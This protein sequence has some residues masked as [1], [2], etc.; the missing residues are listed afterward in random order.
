V[1]GLGQRVGVVG[2]VVDHGATPTSIGQIDAQVMRA[3]RSGI[4]SVEHSQQIVRIGSPIPH[5]W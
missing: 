3:S 2:A 1:S 4:P 5:P